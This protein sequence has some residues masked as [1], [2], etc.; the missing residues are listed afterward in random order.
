MRRSL[1]SHLLVILQL[2][3]I[4]LCCIPFAQSPNSKLLFLISLIG[5]VLAIW[6]FSANRPGNFSVYPEPL[7]HA[8]LITKGPYQY[9]RHPM[10]SALILVMIGITFYNGGIINLIGLIMVAVAVQFK[11]ISEERYLG[12]RFAEYNQYSSSRKRFI[13]FVY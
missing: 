9:L 8:A 2:T 3:G 12:Q 4:I 1:K 5:G 6:T 11:A 10:Y 7:E 13:P